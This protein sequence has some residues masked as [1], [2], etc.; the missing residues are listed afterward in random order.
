MDK[1]TYY[2]T[3]GIQIRTIIEQQA[4]LKRKKMFI[5]VEQTTQ[6]LENLQ[7]LL[8]DNKIGHEA[9]TETYVRYYNK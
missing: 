7:D 3:F 6:R 2:S 8:V 9:Y 5:E 1:S 4:V